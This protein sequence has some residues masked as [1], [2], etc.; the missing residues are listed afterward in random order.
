MQLAIALLAQNNQGFRYYADELN[1]HSH[2]E[3][4]TRYSVALHIVEERLEAARMS[5]RMLKLEINSN[6]F[7]P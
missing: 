2:S 5:L 1:G 6:F 7:V 4:S 3:I